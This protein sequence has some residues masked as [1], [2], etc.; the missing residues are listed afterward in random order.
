MGKI[1]QYARVLL[2]PALDFALPP[3]CAGCG[4]IVEAPDRFCTSCWS[5]LDFL[6]EA[7]CL[8]CGIPMDLSGQ[9]C[10][11]CMAEPPQHD[12]VRA[13]VAY[14]DV[15]RVVAIRLKHGRRTGL[16]RLMAKAMVRRLP[17]DTDVIIPV[18]LHRWRIW[19]RGFNQSMLVA[20]E[21]KQ[22]A[23]SS[24]SFVIAPHTLLRQKSTPMLGGLGRKERAKSVRGAFA[25]PP[26]QRAIIHDRHVVLI[27]DVYTSGATANACALA[28]K[29]AGASRVTILC[30]ARV[31]PDRETGD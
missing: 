11:P 18:P 5:G 20:Q 19:N 12:G 31:L 1:A 8:R 14:G 27:D 25:V 24:A 10:A 3:R 9:V 21:M 17:D 2:T 4:I 22:F 16:A 29:R 28:L 13:A 6:T 15:A 30:W 23:P 26:D 7:G